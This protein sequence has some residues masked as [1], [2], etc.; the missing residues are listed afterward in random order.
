MR[1]EKPNVWGHAVAGGLLGVGLWFFEGSASL[2]AIAVI[3]TICGGYLEAMVKLQWQM[4]G[5]K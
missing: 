2:A 4:I 5:G 1:I 3:L